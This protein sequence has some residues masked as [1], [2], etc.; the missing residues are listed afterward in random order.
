MGRP[1]PSVFGVWDELRVVRTKDGMSPSELSRIS[2]VSPAYL[3]D[4]ENGQRFPNEKQVK[5]LAAAL[6]VPVSVLERN[7]YADSDGNSIALR[8]LI[9]EVVNEVLDERSGANP[10]A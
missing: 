6:N 2:G 8:A 4:L 3:S 7:R 5:K 1:R 9:R 10:A